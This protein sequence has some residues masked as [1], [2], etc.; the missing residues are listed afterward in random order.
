MIPAMTPDLATQRVRRRY[1][2]QLVRYGIPLARWRADLHAAADGAAPGVL[3]VRALLRAAEEG[4]RRYPQAF[5]AAGVQWRDLATRADLA[6]F[7]L[8]AREEL[9]RRYA[10][11]LHRDLGGRVAAEGWLGTSSG[12]T[13]E[14]V[15]FFMDGTS[16]HFYPLFAR[17]VWERLERGPLPRPG[18][19]GIVLLCTLPRSALFGAWLPLFRGT[20]FRKVHLAEP[21]AGRTLERLAPAI[22]SGDPDSLAG[23]ASAIENGTTR[24]R[25]RLVLSSAF[26]L[27]PALRARIAAATGAAVVDVWSMAETGPLAWRCGLDPEERF[28]VLDA[29]AVVE[30][31]EGEL[32]VTNLRNLLFPLVRYRTGDL[33]EVESGGAGR[34]TEP[35]ACG[36]RGPR[37]ACFGGRIAARFTAPDGRRVDPAQLHPLLSRLGVRQFRLEQVAPDDVR[38]SWFG[39]APALADEHLAALR[40]ALGVLLGVPARLEI[41]RSALPLTAPGEKPLPFRSALP[42]HLGAR[43]H[44]P[45]ATRR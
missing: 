29:A 15:R 27:E 26:A 41:A 22:V 10:D 11:L 25:P 13:G 17:F 34:G 19:T 7:P 1:A 45:A 23:L 44:H 38:L 24:V 4:T 21:D 2:W 8:L 20:R 40:R 30:S 36:V 33:G 14:P 42:T 32:V 3:R 6:H 31:V 5:A 35:C 12:S 39:D 43:A 16:V 37:I 28:H 9:Q 18:S